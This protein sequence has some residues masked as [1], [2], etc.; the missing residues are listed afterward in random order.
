MGLFSQ[1]GDSAVDG[2]GRGVAQLFTTVGWLTIA[3]GMSAAPCPLCGT[4]ETLLVV[5]LFAFLV[6]DDARHVNGAMLRVDG[7]MCT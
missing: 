4:T 3:V 2:L 6:S 1:P 5:L 7:A